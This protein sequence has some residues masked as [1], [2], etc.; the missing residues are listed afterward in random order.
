[1]SSINSSIYVFTSGIDKASLGNILKALEALSYT[2]ENN[3]LVS[4]LSP[5]ISGKL[6]KKFFN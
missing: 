5:L 2:D 3:L 1:M 4:G 6:I